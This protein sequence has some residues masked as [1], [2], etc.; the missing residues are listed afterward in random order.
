MAATGERAR[1]GGSDNAKSQPAILPTLSDLAISKTQSS[2]WQK[3]AELNEDDF[4]AR[5]AAAKKQ[6]SAAVDLSKMS[7]E[8]KQASGHELTRGALAPMG[9]VPTGWH[10]RLLDEIFFQQVP[11]S[12]SKTIP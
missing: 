3:L 5:A 4:E 12:I 8:E 11:G 10:R 2:R 1:R 7:R 6:A 9:P